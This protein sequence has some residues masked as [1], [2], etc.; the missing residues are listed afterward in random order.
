LERLI[1]LGLGSAGF[2]AL[3]SAKKFRSDTEIIIIDKKNFDLLHPCGLPYALEGILPF[4]SLMHDIGAERMNIK[5]IR[6]E[7]TKID[8]KNKEV[9]VNNDQILQYDKLVITS[10]ASPFVPPIKGAKELCGKNVFTVYTLEDIKELNSKAEEG[11]TAIVIGAGAIGLEVA[12]ALKEKGLNIKIIETMPQI[13]PRAFDSD[14]ALLVENY[15]KERGI[16]VLLGKKVEE[17]RE[18]AVTVDGNEVKCDLVVLSTGIRANTR[19]AEEAGIAIGEKNIKVNEYLQTNFEDI[20]AAGDVVEIPNIIDGKTIGVGLANAAYLQGLIAG[21]NALF[22]K[23]KYAGTSLTFV[24]VVGKIEVAS[25]GFTK[26]FAEK[27]GIKV[28]ESRVKG[29]N[30]YEWYPGAKELTVKILAD[31]E[32]GR[33]LGAQA[34]GEDAYIRINVIATAI[35]AGMKVDELTDVELAYCPPISEAYDVLMLAAELA[36]RKIKR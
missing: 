7:A 24:S 11:K 16:E 12:I 25:T 36:K 9:H 32:T 29:K 35:R 17:M 6:G 4:D 5:I 31:A 27:Q 20:Y 10:G 13:L 26:S 2:A 19:I 1:I 30:K 18:N 23:R 15:L 3:L 21:Q 28:I 14:M 33:I 8:A 34:V 22:A